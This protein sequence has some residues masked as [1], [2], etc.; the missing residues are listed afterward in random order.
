MNVNEISDI[1]SNLKSNKSASYDEISPKV[2]KSLI[3]YISKPLCEIFNISFYTG[4]FPDKLKIAIVKSDNKL[5]VNNYRPISVL[6]V[7]YMLLD[8][9]MHCC[10]I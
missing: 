1:V 6:P 2:I 4:K 8:R 9:L 5:L 7:F 10:L 3:P